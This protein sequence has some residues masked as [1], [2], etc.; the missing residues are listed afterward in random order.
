MRI[1]I[2]CRRLP[3]P[4]CVQ[5]PSP[6][7]IAALPK[8]EE[9]HATRGKSEGQVQ[10][11]QRAGKAIAAQ[12]SAASSTWIEV[13]E[14]IFVV[15]GRGRG[16]GVTSCLPPVWVARVCFGFHVVFRQVKGGLARSVLAGWIFFFSALVTQIRTMPG[17]IAPAS[18]RV[19]QTRIRAEHHHYLM[20]QS[21]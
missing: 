13:G 19:Y 1:L 7:E 4:P 14:V 9:R 5:G 6:A 11:F 15:A 16:G 21:S 12:W 10:V 8:W 3:P 2:S 20:V 17:G 18:R